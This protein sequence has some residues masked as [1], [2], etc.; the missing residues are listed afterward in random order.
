M[1]KL[2]HL[3]AAVLAA[4]FAV[5]PLSAQNG[6]NSPYSR[7]GL[8]V[9][10][11]QGVGINRAM[12]GTGIGFREKNILN[13][14]NPA[15]YS[16]VD[17]LT[18]LMDF[19]FSMQNVN[20]K[21]NDVRMNTRNAYVDYFDIQFRLVPKLGFT[22]GLHPFSNTGYSFSDTETVRND[23]DGEVTSTNSF[24]GTG[25]LRTIYAGL[26]WRVFP[27]LS[28]GGNFKWIMGDITHEVI[29]SYSSSAIYSRDRVYES[30][31]SSVTY[32]LGLQSQFKLGGGDLTLGLTFAPGM[33]LSGSASIYDQI[34]NSSS[35]VE[36]GDTTELADA[37]S[38]P[39][40]FGAGFTF[41]KGKWTI[42]ADAT[43]GKWSNA[44][45]FGIAGTDALKVSAGACF[46]ADATSRKFL[47]RNR[48][49][50]GVHYA[51]PYYK[52]GTSDGPMEYGVSA[53]VSMP[54]VNR[55]NSLSKLDFS[56]EYVHLSPSES[57]MI[58]ENCLR[59]N[60]GIAFNEVWFQ[61]WMVE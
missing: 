42:G 60:I 17:T 12:G 23:E 33:N 44:K 15:S 10:S 57:W 53:G 21:E 1:S 22:M 19:G 56:V 51:Q 38:L 40:R 18:F 6:I 31:I 61:K 2:R 13:T 7:Y 52:V 11:D 35:T 46:L 55:Y 48:Y 29:N 8:G 9:L 28:V 16:T 26:G 36:D 14:L 45:A 59:I 5:L 4:I 30:S 41:K 47:E 49:M 37:F 20:F 25:G 3:L 27:W 54:I 32:D 39:D 24:S 34:V 58:T 43:Y 50:A